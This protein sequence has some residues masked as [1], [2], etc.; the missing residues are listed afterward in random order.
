VGA[1]GGRYELRATQSVEG[2][3]TALYESFTTAQPSRD[4]TPT[5]QKCEQDTNLVTNYCTFKSVRNV[6]LQLQNY[7]YQGCKKREIFYWI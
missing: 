1:A 6:I 5:I 2:S 4:A 3:M 7:Q